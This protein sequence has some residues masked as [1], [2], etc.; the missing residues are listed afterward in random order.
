ME[1]NAREKSLVISHSFRINAK[2]KKN[3][4]I[5]PSCQVLNEKN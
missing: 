2:E 1:Y 4:K 3:Q 5:L